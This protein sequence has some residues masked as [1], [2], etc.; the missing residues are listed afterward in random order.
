LPEEWVEAL[1]WRSI[2]P[3]NMSGR[4]TALAVVES[5]PSTWWAATASGG[6]LKTT[7]NGITFEHQ[8]DGEATVSIGDV[9][10][11]PSNPDIVW[12][13]TG[14]ANPRNSVS[15]GDGVYKSVDGGKTWKNMGLEKTYQIGRIAIH[16]EHPEVVYVGAMGRLWGENEERGLYKTTDGGETWNKILYVDERTGVIDVNLHPQDPDTLLVATYERQRDGFDG[17]DPIKKWGPGSGLW[18]SADAGESFRRIQAG[19]PTQELGRID[20]DYYRGDPNTVYALVESSRI[21]LEPEDAAYVGLN[22]EDAD[23]GARVTEVSAGSP[24]EAAGLAQGDIVIALGDETVHSYDDLVAKV[25][26][27]LAG[28]TVSIEVSR[29]RKSVVRDVTFARFPEAVEDGP[30]EEPIAAAP[31]PVAAGAVEAGAK[32][33]PT[34]VEGESAEEIVDAADTPVAEA[35]EEAATEESASKEGSEAAPESEEAAEAASADPEAKAEEKAPEP[36]TT[37]RTRLGGQVPNVQDQQG[38]EGH[39]YGGL[40][41]STDGGETWMRINSVNPRPMYFSQLRVDPSDDQHIYV[42]G[43][44]LHRSKDGG[45]TFTDDGGRR[46]HADQHALWIDPS[47]GRHAILGN[48]GGVYVTYDRLDNWDHYNHV[49]IGQFYHV[50]VDP[51]V[52]YRVYGGLQDNGTW[53]GPVRARGWGGTINEDWFNIGGG[54]GFICRVDPADPDQVYFESQNGS[55]GRR[56]L[57]TGERGFIRPQAPR[58]TRYRWN[59]MTPF[60]LSNHNSGIYYTAGNFVFRSWLRGDE[61][62]AISPEITNTDQGAGS[63]LAESPL[64]PDVLYVGTTDGALWMTKN[65]GVDWND[66]FSHGKSPA[67]EAQPRA[68]RTDPIAASFEPSENGNGKQDPAQA[69]PI[70]G[71]WTVIGGGGARQARGGQGGG[72][73]GQGRPGAAGAARAEGGGGGFGGMAIELARDEAGALS[74]SMSSPRGELELSEGSFDPEQQTL[75]LVFGADEFATTVDAKLEGESLK[76]ALDFGGR[77]QREFE[78][79]RGEA[80]QQRDD[81]YEWKPIAELVEKPMWI[82]SLEPSRFEAS[83]VYMAIDGHRS[84]S[85]DPYVF[86]SEDFGVTWRS[87]A[88]GLQQGVGSSRILREDLEN[89]DILYLGAE[90][91][92]WVTIDRGTSWTR[93]NSNLPT[94][95]VH[96]FAQHPTTGDIVVATHGRSLWVVNV[97]PLRQLTK[98]ALEASAQLYRPASVHYWRSEPRPG[99][100]L[101]RFQGEGLPSGAEVFYSIGEGVRSASLRVKRPSGEVLAEL[102]CSTEPGLH[103]ASWGMRPTGAGNAPARGFRGGRGFGR[104]GPRVE[105]GIYVVELV[106]GN[107]TFTEPL[108][109]RGDPEFPDDVLWGEEYERQ[110]EI[111]TLLKTRKREAEQPSPS[112]D[113]I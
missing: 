69:D 43:V 22:G 39:E 48:D 50:A 19:L 64:D 37:F 26:R 29:D 85:D 92:A 88:S 90:F 97:T 87:L 57:R 108:Q 38:P 76:G 106:V 68:P 2:G 34:E 99:G 13:G 110:I 83:R 61:L 33:D 30:M 89:P 7:N 65:G 31:R 67:P 113:G 98:S 93:M 107:L 109:I 40:Y 27:H 96:E 91:G 111:D 41:K 70:S 66:R 36:R 3:A 11:A 95:A 17:N 94:V 73:P 112:P 104:R 74:G 51:R 103:S 82:S 72:R 46:V 18:K 101:R 6:L 79:T 23:V 47:D 63:A 1:R 102:E 42:M 21:G 45:E 25:R 59:W 100:T 105:P 5:N 53:G 52:N 49:A 86:V 80:R 55:M 12:V 71:R 4:I 14:E 44:R 56:N 60:I 16:P 8:F 62:K 81:G 9:Q 75:H 15:W 10:V 24:A 35:A 32:Q 77:F 20:V 28:D 58:G 78:A 84:N 54:D